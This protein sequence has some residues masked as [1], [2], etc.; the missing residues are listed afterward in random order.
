[1]VNEDKLD[2]IEN[3]LIVGMALEDAY[4]YAHLT[5]RELVEVQENQELQDHYAAYTKSFEYGLL[6]NLRR[7]CVQEI[8][9]GKSETSRWLLERLYP[10]YS[11]KAQPETQH[12]SLHIDSEPLPEGMVSIRNGD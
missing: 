11:G 5:D 12:I 9:H 10:R 3:A 6:D 2:A 1:M 4:I 7:T 8:A